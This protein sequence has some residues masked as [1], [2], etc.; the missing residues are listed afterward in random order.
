MGNIRPRKITELIA[1]VWQ[2]KVAIILVTAAMLLATILVVNRLPDTYESRGLVI[3]SAAAADS[4]VV[5]SQITATTQQLN[6]QNHLTSLLHKYPLYPT[7]DT[8]DEAISVLSKAIKSEIKYRGY[9]PDGPESYRLSYR[10]ADPKLAQQVV[11]ELVEL[12]DQSNEMAKKQAGRELQTVSEELTEVEVQLQEFAAVAK[13]ENKVE[14]SPKTVL[15]PVAVNTQRMATTAAIESLNDKQFGIEQQIATLKKQIADQQKLVKQTA[16]ASST[17]SVQGPLLLR[18]AELQAKLKEY[19]AQYT[20]KNPKVIT[21]RIELTEVNRQLAALTTPPDVDPTTIAS[22]EAQELRTHQRELTRLETDLEVTRRDLERKQQFLAKLPAV[23]PASSFTRTESVPGKEPPVNIEA[24]VYAN[25]SE[26]HRTLLA[27]R[28]ALQKLLTGTGV[29]Q[30]LDRPILA[31]NPVGPNRLLFK[32]IGL[33]LGL[34]SGLA[35]AFALEAP[36]LTR[37]QDERDVEYLLGARVLALIPEIL[38]SAESNRLQRLQLARGL[39]VLVLSGGLIPVFYILLK[40][41]GL[42]HILGN[43]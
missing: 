42:F 16:P 18:R 40:G 22:L 32:L 14:S 7:I 36:R 1:V 15:D 23:D 35:V 5:I 34:V 11:T 27:R 41:V 26:R 6:S 33:A 2:R 3:V 12:F 38:T 20:E 31:Q 17:K 25:W 37:I 30:V 28:E 19:E 21:T 9:Y 29:F 13:Q 39:V 43:R 8:T 24:A 10:H 4:P